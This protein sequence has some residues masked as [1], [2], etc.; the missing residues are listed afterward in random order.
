MELSREDSFTALPAAVETPTGTQPTNHHTFPNIPSSVALTYTLLVKACLSDTPADRPTFT[1]ILQILCDAEQE[2][3]SGSYIDS[4]GN[5]QASAALQGMPSNFSGSQAVCSDTWSGSI[6]VPLAS[7]TSMLPDVQGFR[8]HASTGLHPNTP[9]LSESGQ[10]GPE[11]ADRDLGSSALEVAD[12][13]EVAVSGLS[14]A[15]STYLSPESGE[16]SSQEREKTDSVVVDVVPGPQGSPSTLSHAVSHS[17]SGSLPAVPSG[18]LDMLEAA[19]P[20]AERTRSNTSALAQIP[21]DVGSVRSTESS[22]VPGTTSITGALE[23]S[24]FLPRMNQPDSPQPQ[25]MLNT[26][27][28]GSWS[29]G[30]M[31]A[32]EAGSVEV[33]HS[34]PSTT[35]RSVGGSNISNELSIAI[36]AHPLGS[37]ALSLEPSLL[38]EPGEGSMMSARL[39]VPDPSEQQ[40]D[41]DASAEA[42]R[43]WDELRTA[44]F[45]WSRSEPDGGHTPLL[46]GW[47]QTAEYERDESG[48]SVSLM[49]PQTPTDRS[50]SG[51]QSHRSLGSKQQSMSMRG[52]PVLPAAVGSLLSTDPDADMARTR[53]ASVEV[54]SEDDTS[55][56]GQFGF[57]LPGLPP[58]TGSMLAGDSGPPVSSLSEAAGPHKGP[59]RR[60]SDEPRYA[61][62]NQR[63][64]ISMPNE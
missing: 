40:P 46:Q 28:D 48:R 21:E 32:S 12:G 60:T 10:G 9:N 6:P 19:V 31:M 30:S 49:P 35:Y 45:K 57:G 2:V 7:G 3:A 22:P 13:V 25:L 61:P 27:R 58:M 54:E 18:V 38:S 50:T 17:L 41:L 47:Q 11:A 51:M 63:S 55:G 4:V 14:E 8:S 53:E 33:T 24:T 56:L 36:T 23:A 37:S 62:Q 26:P 42:V 16:S 34:S 64:S 29:S 59:D 20:P 44:S 1:Q 52:N 43:A 39:A 5:V 15:E